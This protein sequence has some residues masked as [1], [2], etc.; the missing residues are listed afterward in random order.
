[1]SRVR[2][3]TAARLSGFPCIPVFDQQQQ[4][5]LTTTGRFLRLHVI[6]RIQWVST[7]R[8]S[9]RSLHFGRW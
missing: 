9:T 2:T 7:I 1:M 8:R 3:A 6:G 5:E 4:V